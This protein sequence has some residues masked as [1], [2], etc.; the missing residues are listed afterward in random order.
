MWSPFWSFC[1]VKYLSFWSI[2]T[3]DYAFLESRYPEVAKKLYY[4]LSTLRMQL[5]IFLGSSSQT[6]KCIKVFPVAVKPIFEKQLE[7]WKPDGTN[8]TEKSNLS[9]HLNSNITHNFSWSVKN[10]SRKMLKAYFIVLLKPTTNDRI[11]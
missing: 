2:R 4:I 1:S 5:N 10:F 7:M 6:I 11:K 8:T 9:K 3:A